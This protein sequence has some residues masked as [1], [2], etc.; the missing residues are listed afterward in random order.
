MSSAE[1]KAAKKLAE[2]V[3]WL[4]EKMD[5]AG[6]TNRDLRGLMPSFAGWKM[7]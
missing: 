5:N 3:R 6:I 2:E 1:L 4:L 7:R